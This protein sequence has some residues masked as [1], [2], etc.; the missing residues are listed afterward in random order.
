MIRKLKL[1]VGLGWARRPGMF[2][3]ESVLLINSRLLSQSY[4]IWVH[5][6]LRFAVCG[7][8]FVQQVLLNRS[9]HTSKSHR[10]GG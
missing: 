2:P 8:R 3:V 9:Q 7:L 1:E 4:F 5:G 6:G 10:I